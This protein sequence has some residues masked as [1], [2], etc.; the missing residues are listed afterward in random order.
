MKDICIY[1]LHLRYFKGAEK[2]DYE[3]GDHI[4][5]VKGCNGIGKSTIADAIS[6][7]LFG[8]NQA[9]DTKFGIKTKDE[10]G[11]EIEDVEHSVEIGLSTNNME[12]FPYGAQNSVKNLKL[13]RI[14]TETRKKDGSVTNNYTYK[15]DGEVET[16][17]DFKKV[18][19]EICPEKVFRLCSSPYAFVG[20]EWG[21]Q[22]KMLNDMYGVPS[23]D[24]VTGGDARFD[25]VKELLEKEDIDKELKHLKYN[26]KEI[27][28]KLDEV[29]VRL[30][31]LNKVLPKGEDWDAIQKQILEKRKEITETRKSLNAI[32]NG[33]A[34]FIRKQQN[35]ST[36]NLDHKRKRIMEGSA[37]R[38]L[39][40]IIKANAEA[41]TA[42]DKAVTEAEQTVEDLKKKVKSYDESIN[43]CNT[44]ISELNAEM[45]D[46]AAKWKLIKARTWEWN[47]DD[48]F[49]P[50]C[51]QPL[52]E[53]Q[54]QK[55]REE[56]EKAFLNNQAED[57]KK[58]RNDATKIK[59]DVKACEK[60]IES[61][62]LEQK[63]TQ[64][65]LDKAEAV[66]KEA[67]KALEEQ[68]KKENE[69][70]TVETLLAEK[71]EYKQVCDR[72]EKVEAEQEKP[73][74][75]GMSEENKKMKADLEKKIKD[76]EAELDVL[77]ARLSVRA[78]WEKV[79]EQIKAV[80][81]DQK[82][83]QE[84]LDEL[85]DKI[86]AVSDYQK[87]ACE[88][89]EN[90]VNKHFKI[91]K[92]SMFRRQLDGTDKPWCECS[93]DGVPYADLNTAK[94][95]NAGLDI[96]RALKEYYQVNVPCVIDNAETVLEPLYDGGQQIRLT[97]TEDKELKIE[98]HGD[99]D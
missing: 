81:N 94:K 44:R 43:R 70:V 2:A 62:K 7:V 72:I 83:W 56:S 95:I 71:P 27:Q 3:F 78:Q 55:I 23:V 32:D 15:V 64:T 29:P 96:A 59:E 98:R 11:N 35:I 68:V 17:G 66:L 28:D 91:V 12:V 36:L 61:Y 80:K 20:M 14:L 9:G 16:A 99:K 69:K 49:C 52:P 50:T 74:D 53:D 47:E 85:D 89:M 25:A 37:Q 18:V 41:K 5:V 31:S 42:C 88:A 26:R 82:V 90:I 67:Q 86:E 40:E 92:W 1:E 6:W 77:H 34:D 45:V 38:M 58:L 13:T 87:M 46:G 57:L 76:Q 93:M 22:R 73:S 54:V 30:M 65:Q 24:D 75:E 10:H 8:T 19:D 60:E 51:K 84:Q 33:G 21:D 39:G 79:S 48:A 97:V 4:N 63:T